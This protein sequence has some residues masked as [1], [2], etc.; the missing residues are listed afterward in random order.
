MALNDRLYDQ[1]VAHDVNLQRL[2]ANQR[3]IILKELKALEGQI[4]KRLQAQAG[5]T[6]TKARQQSLLKQVRDTI[7]T[8][9]RSIWKTHQREALEMATLEVAQI[10]ML[11]NRTVRVPLLAVGVPESVV[12]SL[13]KDSVV[14][15]APLKSL[16]E[17][18]AGALNQAFISQ[19]R[20]GILAGESTDELVRRVQG[21][22]ALNYKDGIMSPRGRAVE[23][24]VRTSAQSIL[25]DARLETF[26]ANARS[27]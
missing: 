12:H 7:Q 11:V 14:L 27:P 10:P 26:R 4:V 16:W 13:L 21:T 22:K 6:L 17:Q 2:Q 23:M 20:Q 1:F 15:G 18:E 3:R 9:Y 24:R 5:D 8:G 19:M 25:N